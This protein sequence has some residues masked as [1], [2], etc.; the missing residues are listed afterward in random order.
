MQHLG[1]TY[2][3]KFMRSF[4]FLLSFLFFSNITFSQDSLS[5]TDSFLKNFY[6][7]DLVRSTLDFSLGTSGGIGSFDR[8][9]PGREV[10]NRSSLIGSYT[11]FYN[12]PKLQQ[13]I[14]TF[15][16]SNVSGETSFSFDNNGEVTSSDFRFGSLLSTSSA[17]LR[18]YK[19]SNWYVEVSPSLFI[20][21][22][23]A[24]DLSHSLFALGG[25][26]VGFGKGRV[27]LVSDAWSALR[28]I[29]D[30]KQA[31]VIRQDLNYEE[32]WEFAE[33][34]ADLNNLRRLDARMK[35]VFELTEIGTYLIDKGIVNSEDIAFMAQLSDTYDNERFV[36]RQS[37]SR[38]L[39][40][41]EVLASRRT[42]ASIDSR[43]SS[44]FSG[45]FN[46]FYHNPI[47][48]R[49]QLDLIGGI[50]FER[51]PFFDSFTDIS[52]DLALG[53]NAT[54]TLG[55]YPNARTN[56]DFSVQANYSN[57]FSDDF[58]FDIDPFNLTAAV[59][60]VYFLSPYTS[61]DARLVY[62]T[63]NTGG[64]LFS[65]SDRKLGFQF[66]VSHSFF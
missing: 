14:T 2:R 5:Y 34:L 51:D 12:R 55:Y 63:D 44:N 60:G 8:I 23:D 25:N 35:R 53:V 4:Y 21:Y 66:G 57:L 24:S 33:L 26:L 3:Y 9:R 40:F 28:I 15:L 7:Q 32:Y 39:V 22:S 49:W 62:R 19:T 64:F 18:F 38:W 56:V 48:Q 17:S 45:G 29:E 61:F 58:I 59:D 54:G 41:G 10:R 50:R 20:S 43:T 31:G 1:V 27:E 37:G 13:T 46:Y 65:P 16:S 52:P 42:T 30:L 47:K 11:N 36:P 6:R